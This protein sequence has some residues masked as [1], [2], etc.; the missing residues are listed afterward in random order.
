[1]GQVSEDTYLGDVISKDGS[2][3]KNV[4]SRV[5][6]GV[7]IISQ[8]INILET[9]SFGKYYFQIAMTLRETMFL[10]GILTNAEIWYNL[11]KSELEEFEELDR[12]LLRKV[13]GTQIS[14]PKEA[15][16]LESGTIS[17]STLIKSRR[18]NYLHYLVKE[19]MKSML[20]QFFHVQLNCEVKNDWTTQVKLDM[21]D[22]GIPFDLDYIKSK[23][24]NTFKKL[25]KVKAQEY[26]LN[27]CNSMKGSKMERTFHARLEMQSYLKLKDIT[28]E[29]A[30]LIFA[31]RTRM[32]KFSENFRGPHGPKLCPLC[33]SHLDNQQMAFN[34]PV[35][36][37]KLDEKGKYDYIFRSQIPRE[38]IK[39]LKIITRLR[40][41]NMVM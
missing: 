36:K 18:I 2:N 22:F 33:L 15:L 8:I 41:E 1:M 21:E 25:V 14:C 23:S 3:L 9:V 11:K 10:N 31:Y 12:C 16:Q 32:A 6:K 13:F 35:I 20:S 4:K 40:E 26:E 30:K 24:E 38:T 19:N 37:P 34:C 29:D 28:P 7:G 39:N 5:G 17:I 27:K